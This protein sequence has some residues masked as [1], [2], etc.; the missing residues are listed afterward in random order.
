MATTTSYFLGLDNDALEAVL[1]ST[2]T[3]ALG[4]LM[5]TNK[6]LLS[7]I[8]AQPLLQRLCELR[9]FSSGPSTL[10]S[11]TS[12]QFHC[13]SDVVDSLEAV[14]VLEAMTSESLSKN[15]IAFHL[16]SLSMTNPSKMLLNHYLTLLRRH[17]KLELRIDSHTGVG[18][19]PQV[20]ASHS[21]RR[22]SVVAEWLIGNGV[23]PER[24]SACA[25]GYRV[26]QR[27]RWPARPEFARVELFVAFPWR[28]ASAQAHDAPGGGSAVPAARA[29]GTAAE[30]PAKDAPDGAD[31][32]PSS[33]ADK[34]TAE[35]DSDDDAEAAE[36]EAA[37]ARTDSF[38]L[39][40][41][42]PSWPSYYESVTPVKAFFTFDSGEEV[43]CDALDEAEDDDDDDDDGPVHGGGLPQ[44]LNMLQQLQGLGPQHVVQLPNGQVMSAAAF[45]AMLQGG[46]GPD[47][48][49]DDEEG[50]DD[51]DDD[52]EDD[53]EDDDDDDDDDEEEEE[54]QDEEGGEGGKDEEGGDDDGEGGGAA[55]VDAGDENDEPLPISEAEA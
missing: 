39:A 42:L 48:S 40:R 14:A 35:V 2:P 25:W 26:G 30:D 53:D 15:H 34:P 1:L 51:D 24:M 31:K 3:K 37:P 44:M 32:P 45:L 17:P 9:K 52:D 23:A 29:E 54:E 38:D 13:S 6:Q 50:D 47:G 55:E 28:S 43:D 41:C 12:T 10:T 27:R 5:Q 36:A 20:H 22:A 49:D 7:A 19:P 8:S 4:S 16:A 21:V 33:S 11:S 18:A 46:Q